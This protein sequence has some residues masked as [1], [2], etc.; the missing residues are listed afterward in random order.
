MDAAAI[1]GAVFGAAGLAVAAYTQ[2]TNSD[3][4]R[5][6]ARERS[7]HERQLAHDE[8]TYE[9]RRDIYVGTLAHVLR[10]EAWIH[11]TEPFFGPTGEPPELPTDLDVSLQR[12]AELRA[13]ASLAVWDA[14]QKFTRAWSDFDFAVGTL[15]NVRHQRGDDAEALKQVRD[16][17][18]EA[19]RLV[20]RLA[21]LIRDELATP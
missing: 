16:T 5:D 9:T 12:A 10:I 2:H 20:D 11:R 3:L 13:F 18:A 17:R 15:R 6:L 1:S 14:A 19:S 7:Q 4:Q 21:V 8:W